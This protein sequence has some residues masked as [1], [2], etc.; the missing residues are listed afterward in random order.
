LFPASG[1]RRPAAVVGMGGVG[2]SY[3][4]DRFYWE[5]AA[6]FPGGYLRVALDAEKPGTADDLLAK[7]ADRLKLPAGARAR[8]RRGCSRR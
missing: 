7:I 8:W 3:L 6:R 1:W 4:V 5:N 2:K